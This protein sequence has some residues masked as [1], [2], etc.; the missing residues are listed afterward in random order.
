MNDS[1]LDR[2]IAVP[3]LIGNPDDFLIVAG[4]AGTAKDVA[5]LTGD[6]ANAYMLAGGMGAATMIGAGLALAQPERRVLV[7]T[8]DGELLMG[9]GSLA[10]IAAM[11]LSNLAIVCVDNGRY[12]ETGYQI[13]HTELGC[14][15][16]GVA[17]GAGIP[18][19]RRVTAMEEL[20]GA[21]E[22]IRG[23]NGPSFVLL[24]VSE[25][26]SPVYKRSFDAAAAKTRFRQA[27]LGTG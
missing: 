9:L 12:G 7:M 5:H 8:G 24:K 22:L 27:L 11:G 3:R 13:S 2:N 4:L 16:A 26:P 25:A 20:D 14:D 6:G 10:T 15:L 19:I 18:V 21:S 23:G 1:K 17:E